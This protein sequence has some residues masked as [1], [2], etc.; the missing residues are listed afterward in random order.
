LAYPP[1]LGVSRGG[2]PLFL[3]FWD[4][5]LLQKHGCG[6]PRA[7]RVP[8]GGGGGVGG[9]PLYT[10]R[11]QNPA[12][13]GISSVQEKGVELIVWVTY[14][15]ICRGGYPPIWSS[16]PPLPGC[17]LG[18]YVYLGTVRMPPTRSRELVMVLGVR[19][20]GRCESRHD[21]DPRRAYVRR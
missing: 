5:V 4:L 14:S 10:F 17:C 1:K 6:T 13:I 16:I 19:L 15:Y 7:S 11:P 3:P 12:Q 21:A 8:Q 18:I 20:S 2:T 9:Y